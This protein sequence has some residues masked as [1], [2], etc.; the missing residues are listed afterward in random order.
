MNV[1]ERVCLQMTITRILSKSLRNTKTCGQRQIIGLTN[2]VPSRLHLEVARLWIKAIRLLYRQVVC[3]QTLRTRLCARAT[4]RCREGC[5]VDS[6][7]PRSDFACWTHRVVSST[8]NHKNSGTRTGGMLLPGDDKA[9][10]LSYA[11]GTCVVLLRCDS[12]AEAKRWLAALN[13]FD[14]DSLNERHL[15]PESLGG[16]TS[17]PY[18]SPLVSATKSSSK[19]DL[20]RRT[21]AADCNS[22][23]EVIQNVFLDEF[24]KEQQFE[25]ML[26]SSK[27][28][29][30]SPCARENCLSSLVF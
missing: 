26:R 9:L 24:R 7:V 10:E 5:F 29:P 3:P 16:G 20:S 19:P 17:T 21:V 27:S 12:A 22:Q 8:G 11:G 13:T 2:G 4:S 28:N 23:R 14:A 25:Q 1:Y 15:D 30:S 18:Q 6:G